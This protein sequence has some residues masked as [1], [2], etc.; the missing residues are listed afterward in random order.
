MSEMELYVGTFKKSDKVLTHRDEDDFYEYEEE[1]G[2]YFVNVDGVLYES[3]PV[4]GAEDLSPFG[5][6]TVLNPE[7][8]TPIILAYWYNG[9]AGVREVIEDAIRESLS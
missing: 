8:G 4:P 6:E 1:C 7:P 2:C 9:G 3:S 5:F